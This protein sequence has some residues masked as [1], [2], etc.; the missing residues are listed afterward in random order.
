METIIQIELW[1]L[2]TSYLGLAGIISLFVHALTGRLNSHEKELEYKQKVDMLRKEEINNHLE[3]L[4][5][6][7]TEHQDYSMVK[8]YAQTLLVLAKYLSK[9]DY[10]M[11]IDCVE[12]ARNLT[13]SSDTDF[14]KY[15]ECTYFVVNKVS[16]KLIDVNPTSFL[17]ILKKL[18][19]K[20]KIANKE[21][22]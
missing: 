8:K 10:L 17:T 11:V 21:E 13:L 4:G 7:M 9:A 12:E 2:I 5:D 1:Q 16:E 18:L 22:E 6:L 19:S 15:S 3:A 20:V 14:S